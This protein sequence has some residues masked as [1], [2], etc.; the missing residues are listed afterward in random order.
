M[1]ERFDPTEK[2]SPKLLNYLDRIGNAFVSAVALYK[3]AKIPKLCPILLRLSK[4][5]LQIFVKRAVP[6]LNKFFVNHQ[7]KTIGLIKNLQK[8]TRDLNVNITNH[9]YINLN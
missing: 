5:F 4:N 2:F 6:F 7:E 3:K 9:L 1:I 8:G